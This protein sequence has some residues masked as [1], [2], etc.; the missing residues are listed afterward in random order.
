MGLRWKPS[1]TTTLAGPE[2]G[3]MVARRERGRGQ[4]GPSRLTEEGSF[5]E[6]LGMKRNRNGLCC[7]QRGHKM[8]QQEAIVFKTGCGLDKDT[9]QQALQL[10]VHLFLR[11]III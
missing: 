6:L 2:R 5:D 7:Q 11:W 9:N 1:V 4:K 3:E 10:L 8:N